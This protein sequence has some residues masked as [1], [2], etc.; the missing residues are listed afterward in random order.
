[1][2]REKSLINAIAQAKRNLYKYDVVDAMADAIYSHNLRIDDEV[3]I[4]VES[5]NKYAEKHHFKP[6]DLETVKKYL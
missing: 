2:I 1:M 4:L 6:V 3:P 5:V